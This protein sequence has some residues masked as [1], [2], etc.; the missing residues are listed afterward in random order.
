M[1]PSYKQLLE[2]VM[3]YGDV[4]ESRIGETRELIPVAVDYVAGELVSRKGINR[5]LG[6]IEVLQ[7]LGGYYDLDQIAAVA[8]K[9]KLEYFSVITSYGPKIGPQLQGVVSQL[10]KTPD[11]RRALFYIG[12][13]E[14]GYEQEKPC[15]TL[16]QMFIRSGQ[17]NSVVYMRSWDLINGLAYDTMMFS[18][19]NMAVA[20]C[21]GLF[22]GTV[23]TFAGSGHIYEFDYDKTEARDFNKLFR[24]TDEVPGAPHEMQAFMRESAEGYLVQREAGMTDPPQGFE[25]IDV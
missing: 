10:R 23:T 14:D 19:V 3:N 16:M 6:W 13:I 25:V 7:I 20:R 18:A 9:A 22:P 8:P 4:Q 17:V 12:G 24:M 21:L 2:N 11:S 1:R 15:T 5:A